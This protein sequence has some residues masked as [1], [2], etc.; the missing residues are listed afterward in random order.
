MPMNRF[1]LTSLMKWSAII[2]MAVL[3]AALAAFGQNTNG[4]V[5]GTVTDP[6]GGGTR[7]R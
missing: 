6:Q 1:S 5:I 2:L 7:R 3:L 4:R